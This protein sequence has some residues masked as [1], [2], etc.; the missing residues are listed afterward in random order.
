MTFSPGAAVPQIGT[1]MSRCSTM[2][3][4]MTG[5]SLTVAGARSAVRTIIAVARR[6]RAVAG[7]FWMKGSLTIRCRKAGRLLGGRRRSGR[8][9]TSFSLCYIVVRGPMLL[10]PQMGPFLPM[11]GPQWTDTGGGPCKPARRPC[12]APRP[13]STNGRRPSETA[14]PVNQARR[15]LPLLSPQSTHMRHSLK[16]GSRHGLTGL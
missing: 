16:Y 15:W 5:G 6:T 13:A 2:W 7:R 8:P 4:L 12:T 9:A 10:A 14:P 1:G 11:P 3:L